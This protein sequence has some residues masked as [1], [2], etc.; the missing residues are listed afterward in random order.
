MAERPTGLGWGR[1][2]VKTLVSAT[3]AR[4]SGTPYETTA[5]DG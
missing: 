3:I 1:T 5:M 2:V 4:V